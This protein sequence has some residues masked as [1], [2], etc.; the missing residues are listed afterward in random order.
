MRASVPIQSNI[1]C[2]TKISEVICSLKDISYHKQ[3]INCKDLSPVVILTNS[4]SAILAFILSLYLLRAK[5]IQV[6]E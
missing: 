2:Q 3:K 4:D 5:I 6:I 1:K